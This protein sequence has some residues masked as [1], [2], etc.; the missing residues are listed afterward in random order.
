MSTVLGYE[1]RKILKFHSVVATGAPNRSDT[2]NC[3]RMLQGRLPQ[4][5]FCLTGL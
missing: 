5:R 1:D 3:Y 4:G 2:K